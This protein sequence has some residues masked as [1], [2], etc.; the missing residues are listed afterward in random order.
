MYKET[1]KRMHGQGHCYCLPTTPMAGYN[2]RA[3]KS[4]DISLSMYIV[5]YI[6]GLGQV[7]LFAKWTVTEP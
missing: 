2:N 4:A 6:L 7:A 1:N 3:A 5:V